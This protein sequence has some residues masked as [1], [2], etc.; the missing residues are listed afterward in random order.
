MLTPD[1]GQALLVRAL[2]IIRT[3]FPRCELLLAGDGPCRSELESLVKQKNLAGAVHFA[4]FV[5]ELS[6][7]YEAL[8]LFA[9]RPRQRD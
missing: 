3:Q 4:G 1:K 7:V 8:D 5:E 9:F 2:A 6:N